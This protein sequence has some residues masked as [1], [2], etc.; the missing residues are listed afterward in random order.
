MYV[1]ISINHAA[2]SSCSSKSCRNMHH[3]QNDEGILGGR[4]VQPP[5]QS[6]IRL[7]RL[8][9]NQGLISPKM[10]VS[11]LSGQHIPM[12]DLSLREECF[13]AS[14]WSF[15][16]CSFCLLPLLSLGT[17][18]RDQVFSLD[19]CQAGRGRNQ[20]S[21]KLLISDPSLSGLTGQW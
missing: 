16:C 1:I 20:M 4:L 10:G 3:F 11:K 6:Q 7:L 15:P 9:S 12:F 13:L 14:S 21:P 19:P 18:G 5:A 17:C 2:I 8:L